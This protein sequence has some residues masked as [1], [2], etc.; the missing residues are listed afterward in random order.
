MHQLASILLEPPPFRTQPPSPSQT[1]F[2]Q[3]LFLVKKDSIRNSP[4]AK[5]LVAK[6]TVSAVQAVLRCRMRESC[7]HDLLDPVKT[8]LQL[9]RLF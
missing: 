1:C 7:G 5:L 4:A 9:G 8:W 2:Q 3:E 6:A